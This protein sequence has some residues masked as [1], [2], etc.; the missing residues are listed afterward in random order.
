MIH[1][2]KGFAEIYKARNHCSLVILTSIQF[3][4]DEIQ[5]LNEV[6]AGRAPREA[7]KLVNINMGADVGPYPLY[8]EPLQALAEEGSK[9]KVPK[10]VFRF[11]ALYFVYWYM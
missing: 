4:M 1:S 2:V 11:W 10:V 9:A 8:K 5:H 3:L 7:T 6:V